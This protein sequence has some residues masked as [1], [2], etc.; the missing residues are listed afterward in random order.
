MKHPQVIILSPT[1]ELALQTGEVAKRMGKYKPEITMR[2]VIRGEIIQRNTKIIDH[3]L[4][5]T[6]GKMIDWALKY[7]FFDIKKISVFV[8]DEADVMIDTQGLRA[9]SIKLKQYLPNNCQMMFFSATYSEEIFQFARSIV[10]DPIVIL[11]LRVEEQTLNNINQYYIVVKDEREKYE[12]LKNI[13]GTICIGQAFIFC[14]TKLSASQLVQQL[15]SVCFFV[16]AIILKYLNNFILKGWT[17]G[18]F[19][20]GRFNCGTT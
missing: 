13:F 5:G 12:A 17:F 14:E 4:I 19:N 10:N 11:K 3:I 20:F 8:L 18:G 1:Y 15:R 16:N 2:Y 6:P 9:Q 7:N